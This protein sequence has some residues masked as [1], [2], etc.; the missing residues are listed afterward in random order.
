MHRQLFCSSP[1]PARNPRSSVAR[2]LRPIPSALS[3][4]LSL[5]KEGDVCKCTC[6]RIHGTYVGSSTPRGFTRKD[7]EDAP[8]SP[9]ASTP[10]VSTAR[11]PCWGAGGPAAAVVVAVVV[12]TEPSAVLV[13]L[14]DLSVTVCPF[15]RFRSCRSLPPHVYKCRGPLI[16]PSASNHCQSEPSRS[17]SRESCCGGRFS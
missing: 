7:C 8:E 16:D 2:P 17:M 1:T 3:L 10:A 11:Q 4:S 5:S 12:A 6:I 14:L 9:E 13:V 15:L